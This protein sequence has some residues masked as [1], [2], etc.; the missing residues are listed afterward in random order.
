[1]ICDKF[2]IIF[3]LI[4]IFSNFSISGANTILNKCDWD[5]RDRKPCVNIEKNISNTSKFTSKSINKIVISK[6]QIDQINAVDLIDVLKTIPNLNITQSGPKG[7]QASVFMRGTGSNHT[8]VMI[9]GIP[10]NDQSTT[11]ST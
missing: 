2:K 9:N 10:I 8:L 7:Q 6:K 1:M 4:F 11:W 3:F 5:N